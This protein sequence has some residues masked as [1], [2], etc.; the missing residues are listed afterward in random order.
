MKKIFVLLF[1][2]ALLIAVGCSN[3]LPTAD[4]PSDKVEFV[5]A[6]DNAQLAVVP[7]DVNAPVMFVQDQEDP[8]ISAPDATYSD[9]LNLPKKGD[10]P[11]VWIR[12]FLAAVLVITYELAARKIITAKSYSIFGMLYR[13]LNFLFKDKALDGT[14]NITPVQKE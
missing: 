14:H 12:W 1:S 10:A 6:I 3:Q 8:G 11:A 5:Q 13:L 7:T 2:F 9:I 4:P